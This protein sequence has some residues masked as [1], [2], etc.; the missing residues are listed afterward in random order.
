MCLGT[1]WRLRRSLATS[2]LYAAVR[3]LPEAFCIIGNAISY[4]TKNS[5]I[6]LDHAAI[7]TYFPNYQIPVTDAISLLISCTASDGV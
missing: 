3:I 2:S 4:Y 1:F 5:M 6:Y 7:V